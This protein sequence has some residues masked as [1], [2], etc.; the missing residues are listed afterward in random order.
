MLEAQNNGRFKT[1]IA[2]CGTF[3]LKTWY[4]TTEELWFANFDLGG[5]WWN[6][7]QPKSYTESDPINF[8]DKWKAPIMIITGEKDFRI[9]YTQS[10]E[11]FQ[12]CQL[13]GI[14]SRLLVFPDEGHWILKPQNSEFWYTNVLDWLRKHLNP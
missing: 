6:S 8:I 13:K 14:K 11:A 5:P 1:F 7:P 3:D 2:H 4:S 12:I 10:L 9:P